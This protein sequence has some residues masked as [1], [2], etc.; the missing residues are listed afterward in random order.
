M[1]GGISQ[2]TRV[3]GYWRIEDGAYHGSGVGLCESYT[4][5]PN[6]T[7][8]TLRV[9]LHAGAGRSAWRAGAC[10][11]RAPQLR[12]VLGLRSDHWA[13]PEHIKPERI[14]SAPF[15]WTHGHSYTLTIT[16]KGSTLHAEITDGEQTQR[17]EWT[18]DDP[19]LRGQIGLCAWNNSHTRFTAVSV[20][21]V[22]K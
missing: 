11:R 14:T 7:D 4:G 21:P 18:D 1:S 10:R 15:A 2:W 13:V 17:L 12:R 19:L 20:Q 8:Y 16:A 5:D 3:R 22:S 9:Q 6:W